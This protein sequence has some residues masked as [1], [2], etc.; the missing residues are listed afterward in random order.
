[1]YDLPESWCRQIVV[2]ALSEERCAELLE[3]LIEGGSCTLDA[4]TKRLVLVS[5]KQLQQLSV[6]D[7]TQGGD[8]HRVD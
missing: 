6:A 8:N 5:G 4:A 7:A 1:M 2:A 3:C